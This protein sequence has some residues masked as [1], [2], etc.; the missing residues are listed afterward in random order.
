MAENYPRIIFPYGFNEIDE[1]EM[2][3]RGCLSHTFVELENG[4]RYPVEF[5]EPVRLGQ[6]L[7]DYIRSE[8]PCYAEAGLIVIPEVTLPRIQEAVKYL[9]ERGFFNQFKPVN[10]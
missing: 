2:P 7:A 10:R 8:I 3:L 4:D 6:D 9:Y 5:I 1:Y